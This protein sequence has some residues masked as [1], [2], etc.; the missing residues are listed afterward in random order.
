MISVDSEPKGAE[1]RS[2]KLERRA[3]TPTSFS[4]YKGGDVYVTLAKSGHKEQ[5]V[6][7]HRGVAPSFVANLLLFELFPVGMAID[8]LSGSMWNYQD[9]VFVEFDQ[10]PADFSQQPLQRFNVPYNVPSQSTWPK[11]NLSGPRLGFSYL[12]DEAIQTINKEISPH[13]TDRVGSV[14]TQFGWH[15]E[16]RFIPDEESG[17]T[18]VW[19]TIPLLGGVNRNLFLPSITGIMGIRMANGM[20]FGMGPKLSYID[21]NGGE[22]ATSVVYAGGITFKRGSVNIPFNIAI[23]P[24][25]DGTSISFLTGFNR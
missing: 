5:T 12:D 10:E 23:A 3:T 9:T 13:K 7:L 19:E 21:N 11:S 17:V 24:S 8:F 2:N 1:I 6:E 25:Q 20:E 18:F 16:N 22:F 4:F 15:F 14:I